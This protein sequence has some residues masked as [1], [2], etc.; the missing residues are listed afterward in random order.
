MFL[1]C[2]VLFTFPEK[3]QWT[4]ANGS[5]KACSFYENKKEEDETLED[6]EEPF[7]EFDESLAEYDN[8]DLGDPDG[9][10]PERHFELSK[11]YI[12]KR[13][14][15][16]AAYLTHHG[17]QGEVPTRY[18]AQNLE[19]PVSELEKD[20]RALQYRSRIEDHLHLEVEASALSRHLPNGQQIVLEGG[21]KVKSGV[22]AVSAD[23]GMVAWG[24]DKNE[25]QFVDPL[26]GSLLPYW[27]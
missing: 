22:V 24:T 15:D 25:I 19:K 9:E 7:E 13:F 20:F 10:W 16:I 5:P 8:Y 4:T 3:E 1:S 2:M 14:E 11:L 23:G 27:L 18:A 26:T 12:E 6:E 21:E 17:L